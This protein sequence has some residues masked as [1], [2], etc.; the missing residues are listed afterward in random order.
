M[1]IDQEDVELFVSFVNKRFGI[2]AKVAENRQ[3]Y[4]RFFAFGRFCQ[5]A[6][7]AE[8]K[9]AQFICADADV[10]R[11]ITRDFVSWYEANQLNNMEESELKK[12]LEEAYEAAN[13]ERH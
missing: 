13:K 8:G 7:V 2:D 11:G 4:C 10:Y 3:E 9:K 6:K 5:L 1:I 12:A